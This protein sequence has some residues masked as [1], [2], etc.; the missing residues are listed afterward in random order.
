M[1]RGDSNGSFLKDC[2]CGYAFPQKIVMYI[3]SLNCEVTSI[4]VRFVALIMEVT[5]P[6]AAR[7]HFA[8]RGRLLSLLV[9]RY[10][11]ASSMLSS[12][13]NKAGRIRAGYA[14]NAGTHLRTVMH[15]GAS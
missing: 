2:D 15:T 8:F 3:K 6:T 9:L 4:Y 11:G 12:R 13:Y 7:I 5:C 14:P 10:S 1:L